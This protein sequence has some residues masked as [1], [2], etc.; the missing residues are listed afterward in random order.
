MLGVEATGFK[1]GCQLDVEVI[2]YPPHHHADQQEFDGKPSVS[3]PF[4]LYLCEKFLVHNYSFLSPLLRG[5]RGC[6]IIIHVVV[7]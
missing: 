4:V 7:F 2:G 6:V 3:P 5:G 1:V